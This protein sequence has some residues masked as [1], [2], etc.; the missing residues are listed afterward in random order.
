MIIN[1]YLLKASPYI[2]LGI[3]WRQIDNFDTDIYKKKAFNKG[4]QLSQKFKKYP[5]WDKYAEPLIVRQFG[6]IFSIGNSFIKGLISDNKGDN[7]SILET[8][9]G[10]KEQL[11]SDLNAAK[12]H[13]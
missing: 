8:I 11:D 6:F 2:A 4:L 3:A 13:D 9:K 12:K 10:M 1:R 7:E 5:S